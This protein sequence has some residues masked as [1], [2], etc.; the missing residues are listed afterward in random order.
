MAISPA[1]F[2]AF[3]QATGAPVPEDAESR[4]RIAP[5][6]ME[7]RRNQLKQPKEEGGLVDTLGKI[8]LGA[9]ALAAG[10]AGYRSLR[11]RAAVSPV[12]VAVQEEVVRRAAQPIPRLRGVT[13][14]VRASTARRP[15]P[16]LPPQ[17]NLQL[18]LPLVN[19]V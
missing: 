12:N 13:E 3:S 1:D 8:A 11:G 6:V 16:R 9:G 5:Q 17:L 19:V 18:H 10:I 2:Y 7:W 14:E 4:A 15:T